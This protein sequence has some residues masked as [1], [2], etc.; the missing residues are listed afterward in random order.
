MKILSKQLLHKMK[1]LLLNEYPDR[2]IDH[3]YTRSSA[4]SE[5]LIPKVVYQTWEAN[6]LGKTHVKLLEDFRC[7]NP[8]YSFEFFDGTRMDHYMERVYGSHPIFPIYQKAKFGPLK[9][10][11]WRCCILFE[12]GGVYFDI[13][14]RVTIP[15]R[16]IIGDSDRA[17][18]SFE[19]NAIDGSIDYEI[20]I[21]AKELLQFPELIIINWGLAFSPG[22]SFVGK[23][24]SNVVD[25]YPKW[26][27]K[28]VPTVYD[29]IISFSGPLM[30]TK[31]I[32]QSIEDDPT[33]GFK[34]AGIDFNGHGDFN[35]RRSWSRY[36]A[37]PSYSTFS[38]T[39]IIS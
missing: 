13:N 24:I 1:A 33:V 28:P 18:I 12:R 10:D 20:P 36:V 29:A 7:L 21:A 37:M 3:I 22:H 25:D 9:T 32:W 27:S 30:L 17:V 35:M 2:T 5:S 15:L 6:K 23:Y 39:A 4:T 31:S 14:K 34:Q 16:E 26:K 8:E 11:I 38:N 19:R